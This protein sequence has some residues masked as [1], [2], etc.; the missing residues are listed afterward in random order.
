MSR[1]RSVVIRCADKIRIPRQ[2]AVLFEDVVGQ[3]AAA[4]PLITGPSQNRAMAVENDKD[5]RRVENK[6]TKVEELGENSDR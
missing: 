4:M 1:R 6:M 2:E 3:R 5:K